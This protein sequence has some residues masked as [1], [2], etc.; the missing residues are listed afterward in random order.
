MLERL[1]MEGSVNLKDYFRNF[2][3]KLLVKMPQQ[4]EAD[5]TSATRLLEERREMAEVEQ[6]L[7]AQKEEFQ[8]RMVKHQIKYLNRTI[9]PFKNTSIYSHIF[10]KVYNNEQKN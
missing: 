9:I 4:D 1:K 8:M 10:R 3:E 5:I 6:A 2:E 7:I